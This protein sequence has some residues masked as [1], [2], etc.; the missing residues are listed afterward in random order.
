VRD[1]AQELSTRPNFDELLSGDIGDPQRVH[2]SFREFISVYRRNLRLQIKVLAVALPVTFV[3]TVLG[4]HVFSSQS[5]TAAMTVAPNRMV[6][7]G[8]EGN[9]GGGL[10][11]L[12]GLQG[13]MDTQF[14]LYLT[15]RNSN[16]LAAKLMDIPGVPQKIFENLWDKEKQQWRPPPG[17]WPRFK[18]GISSALGFI[19]WSPP[20]SGD[21][22]EF[23]EN[24]FKVGTDKRTLITRIEF[25]DHDRDFCRFL[26]LTVHNQAE[27][28]LR[29]QAQRR[30][31]IMIAHLVHEL[32]TVTVTEQRQALIQLLSQQEKQMM[33]IDDNLPYAAVVIDPPSVDTAGKPRPLLIIFLFQILAAMVSAAYIGWIALRNLQMRKSQA[34]SASDTEMVTARHESS[35]VA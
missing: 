21:V 32:A 29:E 25:S 3:A 23:L 5:Y 14:D 6:S 18:R 19:P 16:L 7:A 27:A 26:L 4:L 30:T 9:A 35:F 22:A 13:V 15:T 10:S 31:R 33:M 28:L 17:I 34:A 24:S 2:I 8:N 1:Q 12:I 11:S 20:N